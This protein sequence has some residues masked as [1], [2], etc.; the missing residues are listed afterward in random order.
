MSRRPDLVAASLLAALAAGAPG[1]AD[2]AP[3]AYTRLDAPAPRVDGIPA[4]PA[5]VV[6]WATWCPP[7]VEEVP[8]LRALAS[9]PPAGLAVVTFGEDDDPAAVRAFFRGEPPPD[10]G[11]RADAGRRAA[12]AFGVD[13]LPAAFLVAEGRIL[14]RFEGPR[15][16]DSR[17]MRRLLGRL[18]AEGTRGAGAGR[19]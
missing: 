5:L 19:R 13:V 8:G 16:W 17:G 6:F 9:D 4:S 12:S 3:P 7:C 15:D 14:A 11:Y 2:P 1:C 18:A 10:L